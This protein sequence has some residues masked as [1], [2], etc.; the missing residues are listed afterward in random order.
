MAGQDQA[1][2]PLPQQSSPSASLVFWSLFIIGAAYFGFVRP[3]HLHMQSLERQC[4]KL[5]IAVKKLQT[6]DETARHGLKL[7][8][9][10]DAQNE[11]LDSAER[12]LEKF[13]ALNDR[14]VEEAKALSLATA[15]L[16]EIE[17][18]RSDVHQYGATLTTASVA[19]SE[20]GEISESITA[21]SN[22]AR[23][24]T[25]S[26]ATMGELQTELTSSVAHLS[27]QLTDLETR[28][29]AHSAGI[30]QAEQALAQLEQMCED[31]KAETQSI[32][33][34]Q[35]QL[36]ELVALKQ[37]VI[38]QSQNMAAAEAALDQIW[39]LKDGLLQAKNTLDK[40]Q[41]LTLDMMLLEPVL[42]QVTKTLQPAAEATRIS[43]R[44]AA[45]APKTRQSMAGT[46]ASTSTWSNAL[47]VF[48]ALL[49]PVN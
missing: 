19:L 11:K 42:D 10:L 7:L 20:M 36:N 33:A 5:V 48:V 47:N 9:L 46:A 28:L 45:R 41:R 27:G 25:G 35:R 30:P 31:L 49:N 22:I 34:A 17:Q 18:V 39:D 38:E 12:V 13:T 1:K 16:A 43:R 14:F 23:E 40:A 24:A 29:E 26:L 37:E 4:N 2:Q 8:C 3:A 44:A 21:S 32:S 15:A 6:K